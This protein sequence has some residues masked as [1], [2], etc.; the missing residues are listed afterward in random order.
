MGDLQGVPVHSVSPTTFNS[1]VATMLST[2]CLC[3]IECEVFCKSKRNTEVLTVSQVLLG[4]DRFTVELR[5]INNG[6]KMTLR[7]QDPCKGFKCFKM[8]VWFKSDVEWDWFSLKKKN[9]LISLPRSSLEKFP[10][11]FI[12]SSSVQSWLYKGSAQRGALCND[13]IMIR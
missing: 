10:L 13:G 9:P 8:Q 6:L 7:A 2:K 11:S 3:W 4:L 1:L 12:N 5:V